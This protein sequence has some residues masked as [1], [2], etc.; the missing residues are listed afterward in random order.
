M[1]EAK[2]RENVTQLEILTTRFD[3]WE[4]NSNKM[5]QNDIQIQIGVREGRSLASR[6]KFGAFPPRAQI[7]AFVVEAVWAS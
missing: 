5:F 3:W 6:H 4:D 1:W 2:W 7:P